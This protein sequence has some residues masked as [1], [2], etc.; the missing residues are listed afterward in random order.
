MN[1]LFKRVLSSALCISIF[2]SLI[3][4]NSLLSSSAITVNVGDNPSPK[5]DIA[6]SVPSDYDGDFES[7][8]EALT[9]ALVEKGMDP[10]TFRITDTAVKIDTTNLDGWY[11]YDHYYSKDAYDDL[12][13]SSEQKK[14]QPYR[15]ADNSHMTSHSTTAPTPVNI[16]DVFVNGKYK[17]VNSNLFPFNQHT[18][19]YAVDEKANMVFA[20]YGTNSRNDFMVYPAT[21]DSKR[22]IDFDLDCSLVDAHTLQGMGFLLNASVTDAGILNGYM[23]YYNWPNTVRIARI[24]N[25]NAMAYSSNNQTVPLPATNLATKS[26]SLGSGTKLRLHV[27]LEKDKVTVTQRKYSGTVLGDEEVLFNKVA[28]PIQEKNGN[29][30]GPIVGY[31]THGCASMTYFTF[32]DLQM[33]YAATAFDALKNVQYAQSADQK[34][35]INLVGD[36]NDPNVPNEVEEQQNYID[37]INRMDSNEIFYLSNVDD[38]L[39]LTDNKKG[40]GETPDH[41]GLGT[42]NGMIASGSGYVDMMADYIYNSYVEK[43]QFKS[44][45]PVESPIPLSN[46]YI[47]NADD[48]SQ[49]MTVHLKHLGESDIV[50]VNIKDK[51][52]TNKDGDALREWTLNVYDPDGTIIKT[53]TTTNTTTDADGNVQPVLENFQISKHIA[54]QGRYTLELVVKDVKNNKSE[55]FQTYLTVF[56]DE[57]EPE[58]KAENSTKNHA[59]ITL[60]DRG[61]GIAEDGITFLE[62]NRG[63]GVAA[64]W[65]TTDKNAQPPTDDAEWEYLRTPVHE[66]SFEVDLEDFAGP[67]NNLVV[68]YKDEC[69]NIG[70]VLAY[71]PVK[72][73]VQDPDGNPIDEY[74]VIDD[75]PIIVLPDDDLI[76][77]P[78]DEDHEFS[79]WEDPDGNPISSGTPVPVDPDDDD[80]VIVVRPGYT[81]TR[82]KLIYN[83]NAAD[84]VIDEADSGSDG[85]LKSY[86]VSLNSDLATKIN[87]QKHDV[88]RPGYRF[89][90][91]TL[92]AAGKI[93]ITDQILNETILDEK[94]LADNEL[95]KDTKQIYAQWEIAS[96]TLTFDH[97][98]GGSKGVKS[99]EVVYQTP[100]QTGVIDKLTGSD[101]PDRE[102]YI[103]AGWT[104]DKEGKQPIGSTTMPPNDYTVYAKWTL[105]TSKYLVHFDSNGGS[106]INDQSYIFTDSVYKTLLKPNRAGY[107]FKGWFEKIVDEDGTVTMGDTEIIGGSNIIAKYKN[108][109]QSQLA[110][111]EHTLIAKWEANTDTRYNVAYYVNTGIKDDEGNYRYQKVS[112]KSYT[113]TTEST[114]EISDDDKLDEITNDGTKYWFNDE[115]AN[116]LFSG[117]VV[118]GT[119][120]ELRL[121]YDRYFDATVKIGKGNGTKTDSLSQ[122]EGATPTV[123]W[124]P[125]EGYHTTKVLV[126]DTIRDDLI[127]AG[128]FTL[129]QPIHE[130]HVVYVEFE[131]DATPDPDNPNPTPVPDDSKFYD[132]KTSIDGCYDGTCTITPSSHVAKDSNLT[133]EWDIPS[134]YTVSEILIDGVSVSNTKE[135]ISFT[136]IKADHEVIVKVV[137]LP[138]TGGTSVKDQYTVTVN[139]YGGDDSV[140]VSP[141]SIVNAGDSVT[142]RWDATKSDKYKVFRVFVDGVETSFNN[143]NKANQAFRRI[144]ANHVV[145][146]YLTEKDNEDMPVYPKDEY[147][148]L[149]TKIVGGPG[150]IT[151]GGLLKKG[152]DKSVTWTINSITDTDNVKYSYY[153]IKSITVNGETRNVEDNTLNLTNITEDTNVVVTIEP[154]LYNVN[155]LKYGEGTVSE[156]KTLWKGQSYKNIL[157]T[158]ADGWGIAKIVV[159][160]TTKFDVSNAAVAANALSDEAVNTK[161][162]DKEKLDLDITSISN[163]HN[164][165]VYFTQIPEESTET[166]P[167]PVPVPD[168]KT[169]NVTV[170]VLTAPNAAVAGQGPVEENGNRTVSWTVPSGYTITKVTVND[171]IVE[172]TGNEI[173]LSNVTANQNIQVYVEKNSTPNDSDI[174]VKPDNHDDTYNVT[175]KI[176]GTGG[177]ISG[178]GEYDADVVSNV[179]WG[180]TDDDHE[181]KYVIVDGKANPDLAKGNIV[182]FDDGEDHDVVVII[183]SKKKTPTNVDT[184]GD[185][186]PDINI[187]TD[188]DGEPDVDTDTDGDGEPDVNIDTDGDGEPD[189]NIDDDRDGKVDTYVYVNYTSDDGKVLRS[190][191]VM[192]G[193][194]GDEYKTNYNDYYG[195]SLVAVPENANGIMQKVTTNVNYVYALKDSMVIAK[196]VDKNGKSIG[197][198]EVISGKIFEKYSTTEKDINGYKLVEVPSNA[199]GEIADDTIVV[200]YVYEKVVN[201]DNDGDGDP[202]VNID[203]DG[204]GKPDKNIDDDH[205]GKVDTYV[206]VNYITED[207]K[208]LDTQVI[209]RGNQ[210]DDYTTTYKDNYYGYKLTAVPENANGNMQEVTTT[211]NYVYALKDSS[212]IVKYVDKDGKAIGEEIIIG[213]KVFDK[214]ITAEKDIYGHKLVETPSNSTGEMTEDTITVTYVYEQTLNIDTNGDGKPDVNVDVDGD[215][216]PDINIDTDGDGKPDKNIDKDGDGVIDENDDVDKKVVNDNK[217]DSSNDNTDPDDDNSN[218]DNSKKDNSKKDNSDDNDSDD[219]DDENVDNTDSNEDNNS[220]SI[221]TDDSNNSST[222]TPVYTG[223]ND[224]SRITFFSIFA[225]LAGLCLAILKRKS[226]KEDE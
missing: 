167:D 109:P 211:V 71:K 224:M 154:V 117:T 16:Q 69:G 116:N 22:T 151:N 178:E 188:D 129:S 115:N 86:L 82:V 183:E 198:Q 145:D 174:P 135:S 162:A 118:G 180:V 100:L 164:V 201:V 160:D 176:V 49:L 74:Y 152:S 91:W 27:E 28:L 13:L 214:Y 128:T 83:A 170:S 148:N 84:A 218:K 97:N 11:V 220:R 68:W 24:D 209:I 146:I 205:D 107:T 134:N 8:R 207:N 142:V 193:N 222:N 48:G 140:T 43:K 87:N 219:S 155:V 217:N 3:P 62:D 75:N 42:E 61:P 50:N 165:T 103:F 77:D 55:A 144:T 53:Q 96:Y 120:L 204:D 72:V 111:K 17:R 33:T 95:A 60:T 70:S 157:G 153:E 80:P 1:K 59:L 90:K 137:K 66:T 173:E 161:K 208:E 34:Y 195:Y 57:V 225:V 177:T 98:G 149:N 112:T 163:D 131:K 114:V 127:E 197:K 190:Q 143:L 110:D 51:S 192:R 30:F 215:G 6:V 133:V 88:S 21:S 5:V 185:G 132:I 119:P 158:P 166:D 123:T 7:F 67:G 39:I 81:D 19:S 126:D 181:V 63:S 105:N 15:L 85:K 221:A 189:D 203:T 168:D 212:V 196:Y 216:K 12:N 187:D 99:K 73:S 172:V 136:G 102:G 124:A 76:P 93:D 54:K 2:A 20:G 46:F 58:A 10:S 202:D 40:E 108:L 213:G 25:Y 18:Y 147:V 121:Y 89:V 101:N 32:G 79:S 130:N 223:S 191:V 94:T 65:L 14:K 179:R 199:K 200:T 9:Q 150:T 41:I 47:T 169:Y 122:K 206:Y 194:Q 52:K 37:G 139:R 186:E 138:S 56:L 23:L 106:N 182:E 44:E 26:V 36:S 159:D 78:E 226:R 31:K 210:G 125:A 184:D 64:Y 171:R 45:N 113:G 104:L 92:D 38:G 4:V 29:G 156:S 175:T 141:S 35:F